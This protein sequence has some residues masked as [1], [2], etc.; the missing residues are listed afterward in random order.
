MCCTILLLL[1]AWAR[2]TLRI[3]SWARPTSEPLLPGRESVQRHR[4]LPWACW[5]AGLGGLG[6]VAATAIC[7]SAGWS[8]YTDAAFWCVGRGSHPPLGVPYEIVESRWIARSLV[9]LAVCAT[10]LLGAVTLMLRERGI[11]LQRAPG[12]V[13]AAAGAAWL[14]LSLV[15]H[16]LFGLYALRIVGS[17]SHWVVH[18]VG[19]MVA[20]IGCALMAKL[21]TRSDATDTSSSD[22]AGLQPER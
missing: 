16:Q 5:G 17:Q 14:L 18:G 21:E 20:L 2:I 11:G 1:V 8:V 22:G 10:L 3:D 13:L 6:Y 4:W 12:L 15:D 19:A 9:F 7:L